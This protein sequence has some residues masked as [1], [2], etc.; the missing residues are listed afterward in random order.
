MWSDMDWSSSRV[1]IRRQRSAIS[2]EL[3]A[4]KT[5]AGTRWIDL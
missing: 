3:T 5:A 4:P 2:G 1:L